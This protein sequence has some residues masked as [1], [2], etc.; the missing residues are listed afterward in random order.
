MQFRYRPRFTAHWVSTGL[1]WSVLL[2]A[3]GLSA[4]KPEFVAEIKPKPTDRLKPV[5][6]SI[7][8]F[9]PARP[10]I[11][12]RLGADAIAV[13]SNSIG[14]SQIWIFSPSDRTLSMALQRWSAAAN[15][16]LVWEAD[17]DFPIEVE[18]QFEGHFSAVLEQVMNSLQDS[19]Y[20]LQAVVNA[21][22][23]VLRIRRQH[24]RR[25]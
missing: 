4:A 22:T 11:L 19:D 24:E 14:P 12:N 6:M 9:A 8:W 18:I 10:A 23:R 25:S 7:K 13:A 21:Q 17:R 16:Q 3:P 1:C 2:A 20:P 15:W 5:D